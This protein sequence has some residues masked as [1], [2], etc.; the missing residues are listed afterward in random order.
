MF[1]SRNLC[2][3]RPVSAMDL[4]NCMINPYVEKFCLFLIGMTR[5]SRLRDGNTVPAVRPG[6]DQVRQKTLRSLPSLTSP[7]SKAEGVR[8]LK[9][10]K[11]FH[12]AS[13]PGPSS[14]RQVRFISMKS[15]FMSNNAMAS[16]ECSNNPLNCDSNLLLESF[17][18]L[19][20]VTSRTDSI[21]PATAP[22]SS[23][24]GAAVTQREHTSSSCLMRT[25]SASIT[26]PSFSPSYSPRA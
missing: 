6:P 22:R 4:L 25:V 5:I 16:G 18:F 12:R 2:L 11:S 13:A 15:P 1:V 21:A 7:G 20:P 17:A 10:L 14:D 19:I 3:N 8:P 23:K 9:R 24:R 26:A